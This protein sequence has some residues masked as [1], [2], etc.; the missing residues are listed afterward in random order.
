MSTWK[1]VTVGKFFTIRLTESAGAELTDEGGTFSASLMIG[2]TKTE[3]LVS[4]YPF[5][6]SGLQHLARA[7]LLEE[8]VRSFVDIVRQQTSPKEFRGFNVKTTFDPDRACYVAQ[9]IMI[10]EEDRQWIA[11][12]YTKESWPDWYLL[13][14]NGPKGY[15][16]STVVEILESF[17]PL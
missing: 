12:G 10:L 8:N 7:A 3:L 6:G 17:N 9:G 16:L 4:Q 11:R 5:K 13:H 14:W 2:S 15:L 1:T